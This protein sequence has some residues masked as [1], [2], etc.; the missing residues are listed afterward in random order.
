MRKLKLQLQI[1]LDGFIARPGGDQDWMIWDWDKELAAY[2]SR[3]TENVDQILLGRKLAGEF[4]P[5]WEKAAAKPDAEDYV[6]NFHKL[7]KMVFSRNLKKKDVEEKKWKYTRLATGELA[8]EVKAL[9]AVKGG[10]MI[11]YGGAN[12]VAGLLKES[13]ID[14][15]YFY[16]N[17]VAISTGLPVFHLLQQDLKL[18]LVESKGFDCG[19]VV[20]HY[21]NPVL[22]SMG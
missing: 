8:E 22:N 16:I 18:C 13:L 12:F 15:Y 20:N 14:D 17:P 3:L 5:Y 6:K 1:T 4:I 2:T 21:K 7:P 19:I 11:V 10:D 9:K